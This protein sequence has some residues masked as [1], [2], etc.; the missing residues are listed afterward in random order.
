MH[1][2]DPAL[3][4]I[5]LEVN[6]LVKADVFTS[7][8]VVDFGR[9]SRSRIRSNPEVLDLLTQTLVINRR[10][11]EM[12]IKAMDVDVPFI[13][14]RQE[15]EDRSAAFRLDIGLEAEKLVNG[16]FEGQLVLS[17]DDPAFPELKIPVR[18]EI[19]N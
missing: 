11:G 13:W 1:T 15:P 6:V 5:H 16:L 17:T 4:R 14:V 9:V 10:A 2:D 12:S 19:S 7:P 8:E 18:G 3:A